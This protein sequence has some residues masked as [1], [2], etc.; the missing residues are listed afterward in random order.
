MIRKWSV[1]RNQKSH[2]CLTT[3]GPRK[4]AARS[5]AG[6][7]NQQPLLDIQREHVRPN[8]TAATAADQRSVDEHLLQAVLSPWLMTSRSTAVADT[9]L[10]MF[11][12]PSDY[13]K[14]GVML[15]DL[16]DASGVRS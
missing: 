10:R 9:G 1:A 4:A 5:S 16:W 14:A 7:R 11:L 2:G 15:L 12:E 8:P 3:A 13:A 6:H